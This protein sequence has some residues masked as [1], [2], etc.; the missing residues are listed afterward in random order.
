[1]IGPLQPTSSS[2]K[3]KSPSQSA[4]LNLRVLIGLAVFLSGVCLALAG[5]GTFSNPKKVQNQSRSATPRVGAKSSSSASFTHAM[6]ARDVQYSPAD[7]DGRF[8]YMIQFAEKGMLQRETRQ[9]G[10]RFQ[11][12]TPQAQALRTQVMAEQAN[13]IQ[14]MTQALGHD[15][16]VSHYFLVTHSG[17]AARLTPEEAQTARGLPGIKSVERERVY[18]T[19]T[20]RSPEFIGADHIW[21]GTAVPPGSSGTR[22]EGVIIAMLDTG[23]DVT[24]P[25]FANDPD[26][27]HGTTEPDK[28]LSAL[29]CSSTDPTGLCNG[30]DPLDHVE[31]GTHTSSTSGGDTVGTDATPPPFLQISGVAPCASIRAYKVC[32]T[33]QCSD[34]DIQAGMDSVLIHGDCKVMNFS[35]SGGTDPWIDNDRRKL[36]LVDADVLVAASAGNTGNGIPDPVGQVNHRGPWILTVAA[37]TKDQVLHDG[38]LSASGP[39]SPPPATQNIGLDKGSASP[40]GT[41]FTDFPIRHF[42]GQNPDFEGCSS[43]PNQF[44]PD[45]FDGAVAL[46]RRG[47]CPFTEKITNAFNAGAAMVVIRNNQPGTVLMDT[48]GQPNVPAYS[49]DQ[50]PGDALATF[51]DANPTD[52]TV[53]LSLHGSA[54]SQGDVLADFSLR[55]PDPAPYQDIQKPD[56]TGPGVLIYAAF[57]IDLGAYG[58]ISGTSMSSPH[59]AGSA[60]LV[61]AVHGDWT[62]S[63]V[64]SALMMTSFN[65]GTK[66]D[67]TTPWDADDVGTGRVDLSKAAL[68]GLVMDETTQHFIDANPNTGGDPNTLNVPS[69]RNMECT[70]NC[71]WTRTVRNTLTSPTSWTA[72]GNAI[73]P[74]FTIDV[75]PSSF[76]FTGG[77]GETQELTIT[78]TPNIN[79]TSAVA[80]GE[81]VLAVAANGPNGIAIPD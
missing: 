69:V 44:P 47:N 43:E 38:L 14:S 31:H 60:A 37:S 70:P 80:F 76:S 7:K 71:T 45:F 32:A 10:Q 62:V 36:D 79:L 53:N 61:R 52:A 3:K 72:T 16:N 12:N 21:D 13:H 26:C 50:V 49:C 78:A 8:R 66:E 40:D 55:G 24:H 81:V 48:T 1:M 9:H 68:A 75:Q 5:L 19:T 18:H 74:G 65:G 67:G 33:N 27:G 73:T 56:I 23:I 22:G 28:L 51:V 20:F 35:I 29:D 77:L 46:I 39:G 11:A 58:T 30:P 6:T 64:K 25:S 17:I 4:F 15:L 34:A 59:N 54:A 42:T 63:E 41:P 57:P 2:M